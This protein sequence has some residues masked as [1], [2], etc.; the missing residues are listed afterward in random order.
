MLKYY[1]YNG[2]GKKFLN[3]ALRRIHDHSTQVVE[4]RNDS[5]SAQKTVRRLDKD[6]VFPGEEG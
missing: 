4:M 3:T 2:D 6:L 5:I 1:D